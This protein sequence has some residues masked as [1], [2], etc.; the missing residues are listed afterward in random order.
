MRS[1]PSGS[2]PRVIVR[3]SDFF[4]AFGMPRVHVCQRVLC[5][6]G[7]QLF[8]NSFIEALHLTLVLRRVAGTA[9]VRKPLNLSKPGYQFVAEL[10]TIVA[11]QYVRHHHGVEVFL[12]YLERLIILRVFKA[13]TQ[14]TLVVQ[15]TQVSTYL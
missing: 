10:R 2:V 9:N 13:Q 14:P 3:V 7:E 15:S 12:E 4:K 6:P 1:L 8:F 11:V 5:H